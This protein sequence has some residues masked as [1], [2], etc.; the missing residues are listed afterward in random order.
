MD[1]VL[2]L[3]NPSGFHPSAPSNF[4]TDF[5]LNTCV[6]RSFS[7]AATTRIEHVL[8]WLFFTISNDPPPDKT[9]WKRVEGQ[10]AG[11]IVKR[12]SEIG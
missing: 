7:H 10:I 3:T 6:F 5:T 2:G 9:K 8:I 12:F 4:F 11:L 1:M